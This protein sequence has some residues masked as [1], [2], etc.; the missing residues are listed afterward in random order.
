MQ[1]F[2]WVSKSS[3]RPSHQVMCVCLCARARMC[4]SACVGQWQNADS[5]VQGQRAGLNWQTLSGL[6]NIRR[7]CREM[8]ESSSTLL[9]LCHLTS[10][11]GAPENGCFFFLPCGAGNH[12]SRSAESLFLSTS[13]MSQWGSF[14]QSA[15]SNR[16]LYWCENWRRM[17][18]RNT[19]FTLV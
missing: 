13:T 6:I 14:P 1:G 4:A 3:G 7:V 12:I 18:K 16:F 10:G 5:A 8:G 9:M 11:T 19:H 15:R 17:R 2:Y